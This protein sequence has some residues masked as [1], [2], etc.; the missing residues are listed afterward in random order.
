MLFR[1]AGFNK[2]VNIEGTEEQADLAAV[3]EKATS[4]SW[5]TAAGTLAEPLRSR[6]ENLCIVQ[7]LIF[8]ALAPYRFKNLIIKETIS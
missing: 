5:R 8:T 6:A 4:V 7:N 3:A 2:V 1:S